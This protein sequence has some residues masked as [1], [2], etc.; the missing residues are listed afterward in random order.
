VR[1]AG[2]ET[3]RLALERADEVAAALQAQHERLA[4]Q[5]F[6]PQV[7]DVPGLSTVFVSEHGLKR[8][9][10][11]AEAMSVARMAAPA[12]LGPNVLLR[13]VL[14]RRVLPTAAYVAGPAELAYFAQVGAVADALGAPPPVAVP[15]WSCTIVEP[16]VDRA[17]VRLGV[18][19]GAL[20]DAA[21]VESRVAREEM[22]APVRDAL[23]RLREA[24]AERMADLAARDRATAH[25]PL[26]PDAVVS[27]AGRQ[28]AFQIDRL[29]RRLAAAVK[30]RGTERLR[31]LRGAQDALWPGGHR[32]ERTL[33]FIPFLAR[34]GE[35][36]WQ[37]MREGA[38]AHAERLVRGPGA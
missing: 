38:A 27:G 2:A 34:Y 14:E 5:G 30:R 19:P 17:L 4:G 15:R 37:Q 25:G 28:L 31:D 23:A 16:A 32:Q 20:R 1:R 35:A 3:L 11:L 29:E 6:E 7:A 33:S 26:L 13:P 12:A 9:V 36:L 21:G 24:V 8:R 22:P 10:P 18:E